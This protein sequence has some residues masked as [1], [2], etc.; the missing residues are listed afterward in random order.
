MGS[1]PPQICFSVN[2][3]AEG[4]LYVSAEENQ[5]LRVDR[6]IF[7][8]MHFQKYPDTCGRGLNLLFTKFVLATP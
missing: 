1:E 5:R 2:A 6:D 7:Y 8:T 4:N 3:V